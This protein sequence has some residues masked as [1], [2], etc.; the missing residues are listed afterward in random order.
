MT[1]GSGGCGVL[2][3]GPRVV[4]SMREVMRDGATEG[5]I[6]LVD[7]TAGEHTVAIGALE[8]LQGEFLCIGGDVWIVRATNPPPSTVTHDATDKSEENTAELQAR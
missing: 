7:A 6:A 1:L 3:G 4:G 2:G 8:G 5:R